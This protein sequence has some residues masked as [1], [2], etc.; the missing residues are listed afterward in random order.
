MFTNVAIEKY[1]S[2]CHGHFINCINLVVYITSKFILMYPTEEKFVGLV[3]TSSIEKNK[4]ESE[5]Y[6]LYAYIFEKV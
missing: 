6:F 5:G 1:L 2:S 3:L 4:H